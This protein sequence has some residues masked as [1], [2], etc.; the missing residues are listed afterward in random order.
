MAA[1][2]GMT[3][4]VIIGLKA[5]RQN[6]GWWS[7]RLGLFTLRSVLTPNCSIL[8]RLSD[9]RVP[10][11]NSAMLLRLRSRDSRLLISASV[12][13]SRFCVQF[14][15]NWLVSAGGRV[16]WS[17]ATHPQSIRIRENERKHPSALSQLLC[18]MLCGRIRNFASHFN[19]CCVFWE[20]SF[21]M[22]FNGF[23][24]IF[25]KIEN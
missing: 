3:K 5:T 17:P 12:P 14:P 22:N 1:E 8:S 7:V 10:L 4:L 23:K 21:W 18:F 20:I 15:V 25:K 9:D 19:N 13:R 16:V 2:N 6:M 24:W 11:G